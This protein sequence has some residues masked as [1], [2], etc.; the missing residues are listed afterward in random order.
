MPPEEERKSRLHDLDA[1]E[2]DAS[3]SLPLP[4]RRPSVAC[5]GSAS[6]GPRMKEMPDEGFA[7]A[8]IF[9]LN[10]DAKTAPP[11]SHGSVRACRGQCFNDR[12]RNLL[13][14][15]VRA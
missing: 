6:A 14:A 9:A 15:V 10:R 11:P 7:R 12:F 13:G 1:S 3:C 4:A 8:R 2:F 5:R